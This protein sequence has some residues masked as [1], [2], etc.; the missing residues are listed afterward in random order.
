VDITV[1]ALGGTSAV[2]AIDRFTYTACTVP[3]LNAKKLKAAKKKLK[4]A[5]CGVGKVT[6]PAGV[7]AKSGKVVKQGPK[8]GKKLAPG[9]KVNVTLG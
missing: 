8:P 3:N 6:R 7:S 5:G 4:K 1:I 2:T 9:T